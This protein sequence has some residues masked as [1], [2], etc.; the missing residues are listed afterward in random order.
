[1]RDATLQIGQCT[2]LGAQLLLLAAQRLQRLVASSQLLLQIDHGLLRLLQLTLVG[3]LVGQLRVDLADQRLSSARRLALIAGALPGAALELVVQAQPK[4]VGQYLLA[5]VGR[6]DGELVGFALHQIGGVDEGV[7]VHAQELHNACF[8]VAHR[9]LGD[10]PPLVVAR[11]VDLKLQVALAAPLARA[12]AHD[13]VAVGAQAELEINPH[14]RSRPD[15]QVIGG[16]SARLAPQRPGHRVQQ[17]GLAVAVVARQAGQVQP[18]EIQRVGVSVAEEV[19]Q[20]EFEWD[21]GVVEIRDQRSDGRGQMINVRWQVA[22]GRRH[23]TVID[24]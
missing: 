21:H 2:L 7:V 9:R 4:D 12:T 3:R 11:R 22:G 18:I 24:L 1:M 6:L 10:G 15:A 20:R 17:R 19:V 23:E 5:L 14:I 8:G 16:R 13:P